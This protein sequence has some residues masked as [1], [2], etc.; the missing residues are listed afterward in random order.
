MSDQDFALSSAGK[1]QDRER[2]GIAGTYFDTSELEMLISGASVFS[3]FQLTGPLE[4]GFDYMMLHFP[5][6][7]MLS[8]VF[9]YLSMMAYTLIIAFLAHLSVRGFWI[10]MLGLQSVLPGPMPWDKVKMGPLSSEY[11]KKRWPT[12]DTLTLRSDQISSSIFSI[13]V[14][15][16]II[17]AYTVI[18]VVA[19]GLFSM[20]VHRLFG[21]DLVRE[22]TFVFIAIFVIPA[23]W[24]SIVDEVLKRRYTGLLDQYPWIRSVWNFL[25][26]FYNLISLAFLYGP[27]MYR[28]MAVAS[29][30]KVLIFAGLAILY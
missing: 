6:K 26:G 4:R 14:A 17:I 21:F 8:L 27:I 12:L 10:A 24:L 7:P 2:H 9:I 1:T 20:L 22:H 28:F 30:T 3:L 11:I 15:F 16:I 25:Y 13:A 18:I 29:K 23:F 19:G 5:D